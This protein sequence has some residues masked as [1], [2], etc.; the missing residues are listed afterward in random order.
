MS[1]RRTI[2]CARTP[3]AFTLVEL[4]VVIAIIGILV[5]MLL[6]AVQ[7]ARSSARRMSCKSHLRNLALSVLNYE[8][9]N[10]AFPPGFVSQP[11]NEESWGWTA[12][13][14]P[15]LEEQALYD[16]L[17][18]SE[19]RLADLFIAAGGDLSAPEIAWVQT[20][21]P[22][23]RCPEDQ[24]PA[25]LPA[26]IDNIKAEYPVIG[27]NSS[28][29]FNGNNTPDGFEPSASNYI[30]IKGFWD[31]DWCDTRLSTHTMAQVCENNGVFYADSKVGIEKITDGTSNTFMLGERHLRCLAGTWVGARNP[32]GPDMWSSYYLLGRANLKLNHPTTGAHNTCTEGFSSAHPGGGQ[33]AMCDGSV[34]W[35][36]DDISFNNAG[37]RTNHHNALRGLDPANPDQLG[38]Y[39]RLAIRNDGQPLG[40]E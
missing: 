22:I 18:V 32:P 39:Q 27:G 34:R 35:V 21:L 31:T 25:L 5:A 33:F 20:P 2:A 3:R 1:V 15:Y 16:N 29:H 6:P 17:G 26:N 23:F 36:P 14:L 4:L 19:R 8:S 11:R 12:F 37:N 10:Q 9:T 30:A 40:D 13:V 38:V 28:R 24:M 7:S